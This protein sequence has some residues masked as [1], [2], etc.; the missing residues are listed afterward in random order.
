MLSL[1]FAILFFF[2]LLAAAV[3]LPF[4]VRLI[5]GIFDSGTHF[6]LFLVIGYSVLLLAGIADILL[7][8]LLRLVRSGQIFTAAAVSKIRGISWCCIAAGV[9]FAALAPFFLISAA[10]AFVALFVG[11]CL[12][13][14]KNAVEQAAEIKSENDLTV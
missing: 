10:V 14:V 3:F 12:R 7:F 9:L 5:S 11:L 1:V 6:V 13:V 8:L 4:Y 2:G